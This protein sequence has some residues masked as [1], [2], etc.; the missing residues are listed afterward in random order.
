MGPRADSDGQPMGYLEQ[1][2]AARPRDCHR[3]AERA[4]VPGAGGCEDLVEWLASSRD[5]DSYDRATERE[6][7][8]RLY[9]DAVDYVDRRNACEVWWWFKRARLQG[10]LSLHLGGF[11]RPASRLG[12]LEVGHVCAL[13]AGI[14]RLKEGNVSA[15]T[16]SCARARLN[17][18]HRSC[19]FL[20]RPLFERKSWRVVRI[21]PTA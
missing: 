7:A 17:F 6:R 10:C 19:L 16:I 13:R 21:T 20:N 1:R 3:S 4:V 9:A 15:L 18:R 12:R 2:V 5:L 14:C 8:P 11:D